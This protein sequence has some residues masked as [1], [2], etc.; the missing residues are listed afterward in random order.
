MKVVNGTTGNRYH[1]LLR[2]QRLPDVQSK[3]ADIPQARSEYRLAFGC[4]QDN[5]L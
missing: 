4:C 2:T 1:G 5:V 3:A